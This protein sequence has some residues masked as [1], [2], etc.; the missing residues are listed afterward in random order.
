[1]GQELGGEILPELSK[2]PVLLRVLIDP[3]EYRAA[4][5]RGVKTIHGD[6]GDND[7]RQNRGSCRPAG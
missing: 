7:Q 5:E 6:G 4:S 2:M 3:A 1:M